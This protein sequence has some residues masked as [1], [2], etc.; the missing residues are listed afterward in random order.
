MPVDGVEIGLGTGLNDVG[1]RALAGDEFAVA[2]VDLQADLAQRV[3]ALRNTAQS[4]VLQTPARLGQPVDCL[5]RGIDRAIAHPGV[6]QHGILFRP[7]G[8]RLAEAH[9][10]GRDSLVAAG[11][12]DVFHHPRLR[13]LGHLAIDQRAEIVVIDKFLLV[14]DLLKPAEHIRNLVVG[15]LEA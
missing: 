11:D 13:H 9:G 14:A 3:L 7:T 2:E 1:A 12:V 6:L 10:G 5:E 4:I 15:E 8:G